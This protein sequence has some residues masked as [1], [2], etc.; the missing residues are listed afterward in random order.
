[1]K[2]GGDHPWTV[3]GA[4]QR[5]ELGARAATGRLTSSPSSDPGTIEVPAHGARTVDLTF[6]V[7]ET[8]EGDLRRVDVVWNVATESGPVAT[9]VPFGRRVESTGFQIRPPRAPLT[10]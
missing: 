1:V 4:S 7:G 6:P 2:N 9:R 3:D 5:V 10:H 8:D